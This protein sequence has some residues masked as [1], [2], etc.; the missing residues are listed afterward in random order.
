[1]SGFLF[2]LA[3]NSLTGMKKK[4]D[5]YDERHLAAIIRRKMIQKDHGDKSKYD[6][7]NKSWKKDTDE[8]N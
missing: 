3:Y 6:K 1:M 5:G 4:I 8:Q 2:I 7:K